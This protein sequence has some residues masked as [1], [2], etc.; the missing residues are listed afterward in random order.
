MTLRSNPETARSLLLAVALTGLAGCSSLN[1]IM[2]P[3]RLDYKSASKASTTNLEVPPDLTQL[4]KDSRYAIPESNR[5]TATAS[6]YTAQTGTL[7]VATSAAPA[8]VAPAVTP[9][10]R[11][12]RDGN[13][14]W[15]VVKQSPEVL[16]PQIKDFWQESGFL[17]N[18]ERPEA[19]VMETD[20]AENRAKIPQDFLRKTL[21]KVVDSLYST[22]ERDK[23]RTRLERGADG[24]TEVYISH[25]GAEEVLT[26]AQKDGTVWTPRPADPGLE[27]EFL[28]RLMARL[29]VEEV[30]AKSIVAQAV[31]QPNRAKLGKDAGGPYVEVDEGFDRAWRRV[32]LSLDRVGFT[33][34][35]RDRVQGM[36][37]VRYIDLGQDAKSKPNGEKGFFSRLFSSSDDKAKTAQKYRVSVKQLGTISR[38]TVLN[39]D[40]KPEMSST[41][42]RILTLLNEQLK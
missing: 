26:G 42:D 30:K 2:E 33:V 5:G 17:I 16:W 8:V 19:G 3:D 12:V 40:G 32:G 7:P 14:R 15:L 11:V 35:D 23:F 41:A 25:R 31:Q 24:S 27:A 37:F 36:Y 34:E 6:S 10:A 4:Q 18:I 1:S 20:W 29:G 22:G 9:E 28:S 38:I 21:G 39:A 13:E